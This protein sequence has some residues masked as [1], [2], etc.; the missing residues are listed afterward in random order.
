MPLSSSLPVLKHSLQ[1]QIL[2]RWKYVQVLTQ[3]I[4][5]RWS[6][7]YLLQLQVR[8][9]RTA[10]TEQMKMEDMVIIKEESGNYDEY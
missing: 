8:D 6:K 7:E 2:R 5:N 4:W 10:K 9:R 3:N 1:Y